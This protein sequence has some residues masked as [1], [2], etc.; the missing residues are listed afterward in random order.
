MTDSEWVIIVFHQMN[1]FSAISWRDQ[2]TFRRDDDVILF[3]LDQHTLLDLY[4]ASSLKQQSAGRHVAPLSWF[5]V[6]QSLLFFLKSICLA[7]NQKYQF[8]DFSL[9]RPCL[10]PTIYQNQGKHANHITTDAVYIHLC[11]CIWWNISA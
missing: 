3:V 10:E 5:Q 11:T 7:E 6:N 8:I 9:T 2:V 1:N 4:S